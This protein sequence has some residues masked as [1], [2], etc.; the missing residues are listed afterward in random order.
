ME[1]LRGE[2]LEK[3]LGR[4]GGMDWREA[5]RVG[6]EV[7]GALEVAHHAGLVHRDLKP[8][9][10]FI[11]DEGTLKLLDFG[12]ATA[13][14][15]VANAAHEKRQKGF[16]IFG[17]PDYMAPEQVAGETLDGRCD[18]YALGAVLYELVTGSA[19][20][21]GPSAVVVMGKQLREYP[22]APR[23]RAPRRAIPDALERVILCALSKAPS[24]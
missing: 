24:D 6:I 3:R 7:C 19:V 23:H 10:L 9:N 17:T 13:V 22:E 1:R 16:A 5:A 14:S 11:T 4:L 15:D 8:A 2:T 18:I 12:V 20:F 21:D